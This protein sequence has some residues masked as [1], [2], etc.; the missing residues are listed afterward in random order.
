MTAFASGSIAS[1]RAAPRGWRGDCVGLPCCPSPGRENLPF[2][3]SHAACSFALLSPEHPVSFYPP[4][5]LIRFS[6]FR[7]FA[8]LDHTWSPFL[9]SFPSPFPP[10]CPVYLSTKIFV[11]VTIVFISRSCFILFRMLFIF[12]MPFNSLWS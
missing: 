3:E 6:C 8:S 9:R 11:L 5:L 4:W 7:F 1:G 2:L 10:H 12:M